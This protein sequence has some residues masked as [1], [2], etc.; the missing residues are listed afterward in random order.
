M[1]TRP[2]TGDLYHAFDFWIGRWD[3]HDADGFLIGRNRITRL[4]DGCAL[5]EEWRGLS[6]LRGT[7][8]N[9]YVPSREVWHQTWVDSAGNL[10]QLEGGLRDGAMV[11][12]GITADA[13]VPGRIVRHRASWSIVEG[14][15]GRVRQH[16]QIST[17]EAA[18]ET[19]F[20]GRY[21]RT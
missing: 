7:S 2:C 4:F 16:W 8:L 17:D 21:R 12:E 5:R 11:L 1:L 9:V 20:D 15:P 6:G 14:D 10:L 19:A 13:D 3:V 18:W